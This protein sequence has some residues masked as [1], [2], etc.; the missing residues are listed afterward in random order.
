MCT[1]FEFDINEKSPGVGAGCIL[2]GFQIGA[3]R[4]IQTDSMT[5][6]TFDENLAPIKRDLSRKI[7]EQSLFETTEEMEV[8]AIRKEKRKYMQ[9]RADQLYEI[10]RLIDRKR[11]AGERRDMAMNQRRFE[12]MEEMDAEC[13]LGAALFSAGHLGGMLPITLGHLKLE[14]Y[15]AESGKNGTR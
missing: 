4:G 6:E 5:C 13:R 2:R 15:L 1:Q 10:K 12:D 14:G 3:S 7:L 11:I 8:E 9:M